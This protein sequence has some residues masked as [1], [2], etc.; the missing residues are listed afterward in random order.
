MAASLPKPF[1]HASASAATYLKLLA[2]A[3][4]WGATWIAGRVAVSEASPLAIASWRFLLAALVLGSLLV[5]REGWR[6]WSLDE[7]LTL[8]ALGAS[9]IFLYNVCFLYGMTMIEAGRGALVVALTPALI[10]ASDWLLFGA[11]MSI[12]KAS[13]IGLAAFG[14]L[15]V[16]TRGHPYLLI[17]GEVG[18]GE[19]L[20]IGCAALWAI[21]TFVGRRGTRS[22]S[23]LA[24]TFG[25][26]VTGWLMLTLA[27]LLQG[28]LFAMTATTWRG[29]SSIVFLGLFGTALA[30]TWYAEAVQRIGAT[31]SAA[32]I[33][34]VPVSA[35]IL[36]AVLL[37]ERPGIAVLTGGALV[38]A[39]VFITNRAGARLAAATHSKETTA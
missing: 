14:C 17:A 9:G 22:L 27:A 15:L 39:G 24:M 5:I 21:Y 11:P 20:I 18:L 8:T 30:F 38:I 1:E 36:G 33:N 6:R 13:G 29:W 26:S 4:L 25:A 28:S 35:V 31:R 23:P 32:F 12:G 37:G 34:L 2:T 3:L 16:V 10:A 19:W 7:W